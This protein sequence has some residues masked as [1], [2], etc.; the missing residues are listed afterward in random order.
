[1]PKKPTN[2]VL[3]ARVEAA[4]LLSLDPGRLGPA[5]VL[6]CDLV[7]T[8]RATI[9]RTSAELLA[10]GGT[11]SLL[12]VH[13][14]AIEQLRKLLPEHKLAPPPEPRGDPRRAMWEIYKQMRE[15]GEIGLKALPPEGGHQHRIDELEAENE[16]LK[17]QLA[18]G[19]AP[20]LLDVPTLVE[21]VPR[22]GSTAID[23]A[24][25][26]ITPPGEIGGECYAGIRP[27]PDDPPRRSPPVIEGRAVPN[28]PAASA[29]V[30]P[31]RGQL[32]QP[33]ITRRDR[34]WRDWVGGGPGLDRW[35]NRNV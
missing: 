11:V 33:T 3:K 24:E 8:L 25:A 30:A 29:V 26:D 10:G 27:G 19:L 5:D 2:D 21:S 12:G 16:R 31:H 7:A 13:T 32:H 18:G 17:A 35:S 28:P 34:G 9:D 1:M 15:R 20:A 14:S 23:P 6:R 22:G 4:E